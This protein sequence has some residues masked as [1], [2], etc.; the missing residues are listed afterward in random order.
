M[1]LEGFNCRNQDISCVCRHVSRCVCIDVG[2]HCDDCVYPK[3]AC[4]CTKK[5]LCLCTWGYKHGTANKFCPLQ[6]TSVSLCVC[7]ISEM[8]AHPAFLTLSASHR[9]HKSFIITTLHH[10]TG[11]TVLCSIQ[12][13][14]CF[15]YYR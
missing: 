3:E 5:R 11:C 4:I 15:S 10:G 8:F 13:N 12:K 1:S 14:N 9:C 7:H 6:E 2:S